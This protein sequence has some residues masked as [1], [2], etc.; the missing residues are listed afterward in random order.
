MAQRCWLALRSTTSA[1]PCM[2]PSK[3][4]PPI[5]FA[6]I[7]MYECAHSCFDVGA[8]VMHGF[9]LHKGSRVGLTGANHAAR[10]A[11]ADRF[12]WIRVT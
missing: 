2:P 3:D 8:F 7:V 1:M 5:S 10:N 9:E 12:D 11:P 4:D 6:A